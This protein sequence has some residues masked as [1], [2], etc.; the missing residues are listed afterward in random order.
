MTPMKDGEV[1]GNYSLVV[2]A[3]ASPQEMESRILHQIVDADKTQH[4]D[5]SYVGS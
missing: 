3:D 4:G 2:P 5:S 1:L